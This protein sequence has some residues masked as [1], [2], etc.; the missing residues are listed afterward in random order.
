MDNSAMRARLLRVGVATWLAVAPL[1]A[2]EPA[3]QT[4]A[5]QFR[6]GV[7]LVRVPVTVTGRDGAL[8]RGLTAA[9][10]D[11]L[12]DGVR[13]TITAFA[14]GAPGKVL[15]LHLGVL[16]DSSGSMALDMRETGTAAIRFVDALD[17]AIDVTL[18]DFDTRIRLSRFS[19]PSY[20][21][22][23]ER[24]R[25]R[26]A[27]G[28]TSLYD[29]LGVYL[30]TAVAR[31]GQHVLLLVT[32]GGDSASRMNYSD[33][34]KMLRFANVI[35]YA[36]GYLDHQSS[37]TRA[38]QQSRLTIIAR[39]TGGDAFFPASTRHLA[40]I[41]ARILDE[42]GSRY[43]IGY[44]STNATRDGRFRKVQ[45]KLSAGAAATHR[46]AKVRTRSGYLAPIR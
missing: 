21:T 34:E 12:E 2:G 4:A 30:E 24:I 5:P 19:R 29:A 46:S 45:V 42:L 27:D 33:L 26:K 3:G 40:A 1:P 16:L 6:G 10:F 39:E 44:A 38:A 15:P 20:P 37:S 32:D 13:Q 17:E 41:Y 35:V 7:R 22:L 8:V 11:V 28:A 9:D 25:L 31:G 36:L 14:E 18:V 23:F 43:T